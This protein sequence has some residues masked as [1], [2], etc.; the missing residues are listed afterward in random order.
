VNGLIT[1]LIEHKLFAGIIGG[2][3]YMSTVFLHEEVSRISV[4]FQKEL[5]TS[6]YNEVLAITGI[7]IVCFFAFYIF[8]RVREGDDRKF[9]IIYLIL[10]LTLITVSFHTLLTINAEYIHFFQYAILAIP[11]FALT[12]KYGETVFWVTVLGVLDEAYQYFVLYPDFRYFDFNDVILNLLGGGI[13]AIL[14]LTTMKGV[15]FRGYRPRI[16]TGAVSRVMVASVVLLAGIYISYLAGLV[17]L[18]PDP[19]S[20]GN[21]ILLNRGPAPSAFWTTVKWG[22]TFHILSPVEG[23]LITGILVGFYSFIDYRISK[24]V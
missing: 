6:V 7:V 24:K 22:K 17:Q 15:T 18:F 1:F 16:W 3:Y 23:I 19:E 21:S 2:L 4:W 5:T 8:K 9:K 10:T 12:L 14:I 11:I 20:S 13:G